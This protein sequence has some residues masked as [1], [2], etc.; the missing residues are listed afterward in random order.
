MA[1]NTNVTDVFPPYAVQCS[2]S[3]QNYHDPFP[4]GW[5]GSDFLLDPNTY[6]YLNATFQRN[7]EPPV[8]YEGQYSTDVL[9]GKALG[10]IDEAVAAKKPFFVGIAP[11][12][13]HSNINANVVSPPDGS[14]RNDKKFETTPPIPA[15]RHAHLFPDVVVPRTYNFNSDHPSGASWVFRQPKMTTENVA[16][17]DEYHRNRIRSLQA[18]DEM[19]DSVFKK[20]ESHGITGETYVFYT[21]DN[22]FHIGQHRLQPGKSCGYEEDINVPLIIRGPGIPAGSVA[23]FVTAHHDLLPTILG[24]AGYPVPADVDGVAIP[25]TEEEQTSARSTRHEHVTVE[26]WGFAASEGKFLLF[27]GDDRFATNNTYKAVRVISEEYNLYYSVWCNNEREL[28]DLKS[29]PGQMNN[30]LQPNA[31]AI[32]ILGQSIQT[33]TSRLDALL[34]VTKTCKVQHVAARGARYTRKGAYT[35]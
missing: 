23:D 7:K 30:L 6:S 13:P 5:T 28:Y 31:P 26:Y 32:N 2:F 14:K 22:G 21:S 35:R 1:H 24:I 8:N 34:L 27:G 18:V 20:L 17:N 15:E 9:A 33:L 29:D 4:S 12:A 10:F 11:I 19:V 3:F 16:Y 25:L